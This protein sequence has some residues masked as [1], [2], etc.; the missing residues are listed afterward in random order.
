MFNGDTEQLRAPPG[1]IG[2]Q[3]FEKVKDVSIQFGK[4]FAYK[5]V[6]SG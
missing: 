3:I 1:L 2:D 5:V 4:P 6:T